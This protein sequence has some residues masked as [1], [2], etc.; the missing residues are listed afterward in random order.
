MNYSMR[1]TPRI[2]NLEKAL[3]VGHNQQALVSVGFLLHQQFPGFTNN[4]MKRNTADVKDMPHTWRLKSQRLHLGFE[5]P[6]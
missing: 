1:R 4:L 2:T 3:D 5:W 6:I